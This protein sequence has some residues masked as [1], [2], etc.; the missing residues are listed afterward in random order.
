MTNKEIKKAL[1]CLKGEQILCVECAYRLIGYPACHRYAVK[2]IDKYI[3][4]QQAEIERLA[5][6]RNKMAKTFAEKIKEARF[7]LFNY[8]YTEDG[9]SKQIDKLAE[10]IM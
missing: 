5:E 9:F 3:K 7:R 1:E 6:E 10:E 2:D 4:Y 8:V